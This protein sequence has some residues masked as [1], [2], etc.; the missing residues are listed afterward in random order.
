MNTNHRN[1]GR[2]FVC[3]KCYDQLRCPRCR[4]E[5]VNGVRGC[6]ACNYTGVCQA[7]SPH[8]SY[9]DVVKRERRGEL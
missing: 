3:D 6:M 9:A 7:C 4:G 1:N 2:N 8:L 5:K